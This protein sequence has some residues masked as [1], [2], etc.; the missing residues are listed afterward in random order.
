MQ[1][2]LFTFSV[3]E[4]E[5]PFL[6]NLVQKIKIFSLNWNLL[7]RLIR[8]YKL[9]NDVHFFCFKQQIS[10]LGKIVSKTQ[11]GLLKMKFDT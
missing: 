9:N 5:N 3:L 2:S 7:P 10:F 11:K 4:H 1:N 8:L 6:V